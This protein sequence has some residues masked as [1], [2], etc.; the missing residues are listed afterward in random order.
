DQI[1][2]RN[3]IKMAVTRAEINLAVERRRIIDVMVYFA[4]EGSHVGQNIRICHV[5]FGELLWLPV[6]GDREERIQ[7]CPRRAGRTWIRERQEGM[8]PPF[9][10]RC[11]ARRPTAWILSDRDDIG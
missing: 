4:I 7:H 6:R 3:E 8:L 5:G 1:A 10:L 9:G 11:R 2:F